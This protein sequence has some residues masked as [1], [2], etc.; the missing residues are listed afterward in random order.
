VPDFVARRGVSVGGHFHLQV[1]AALAR[2]GA[3]TL[4][5]AGKDYE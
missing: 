5:A 2:G 3:L 1:A 4:I